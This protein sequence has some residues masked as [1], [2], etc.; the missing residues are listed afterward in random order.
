MTAE[1]YSFRGQHRLGYGYHA[2]DVVAAGREHYACIQAHTS[3]ERSIPGMGSSWGDYW[4]ITN[5][6]VLEGKTPSAPA[7]DAAPPQSSVMVPPVLR[8]HRSAAAVSRH[9]A[10]TPAALPHDE[11]PAASTIIDDSQDGALTVAVALDALRQEARHFVRADQLDT[12]LSKLRAVLER[13]LAA[14]RASVDADDPVTAEAWRRKARLL[15]ATCR[16]DA[17]AMETAALRQCLQLLR[18]RDR[19]GSFSTAEALQAVH[20]DNMLAGLADI[21]AAAEDLRLR[22]PADPADDL[23]WRRR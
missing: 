4:T 21:D 1:L 11:P 13:A 15:G 19:G 5:G 8:M 18:K 2:R 17:Q 12:E 14:I 3:G 22:P 7:I 6:F 9:P 23:L 10:V 20:L 16:A